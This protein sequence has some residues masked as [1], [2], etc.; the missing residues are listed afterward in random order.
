MSRLRSSV[1][2]VGVAAWCASLAVSA[3]AGG[4][5]TS[6]QPRAAGAHAAAA[7]S[8]TPSIDALRYLPHARREGSLWVG[9]DDRGRRVEYTIAPDLQ[10]RALR[11][12][13]DYQ[14]PYAAMVAIEPN[15]GRVLAYVSHSSANPG[16]SDLARDATPPAASVF[17]LITS[18]ALVDAGVNASNRVCYSG[19]SSRLDN[20][21]LRDDPRRERSCATLDDALGGS[22]NAVFAKLADKHLNH[23]TLGR[24]A[25]NFGFGQQLEFGFA[26]PPS[27]A[28]IPSDRLE[29][30]RTAAGFWHVHMSP[31][32]AALIAATFANDGAMP[33]PS[34]VQRVQGPD[35]ELLVPP[36]RPDTLHRAVAPATARAVGKMMLR[37]VKDGTSRTAF[38]ERG[39]PALPGIPVA[40]KTGSLSSG[41]PYRAYSWW[42]GFAP[43]DRPRIA[44]AVL[45]VNTAVWRIKSSYVAREML[46]EYLL[47][48]A[49]KT[50][51]IARRARK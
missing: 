22:I 15:T 32:H 27:P 35:G 18:A 8:Q 50:L 43:A 41:D 29:F 30:A 37:T 11:V 44:L 42:V 20:S 51:Q 13:R 9:S 3:D 28:D 48:P 47:Q 39:R 19:G 4:A 17:K 10:E 5:G 23:A 34:I 2:A 38:M 16:A 26:P 1:C 31:L 25:R 24:Y 36:A 12:F 14:V 46:R 45:V 40:G 6:S 33:K 49:P 21:H 7:A